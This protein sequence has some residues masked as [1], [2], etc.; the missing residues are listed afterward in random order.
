MKAVSKCMLFIAVL[1]AA[2]SK[3]PV[4][5]DVND[6]EQ[7]V[8][9]PIGTSKFYSHVEQSSYP[10]VELA[11]NE[12]EAK[13]TFLQGKNGS[14]QYHLQQNTRADADIPGSKDDIPNYSVELVTGLTIAP[15]SANLAHVIIDDADMR[16]TFNNETSKTK[17]T[18]RQGVVLEAMDPYGQF[19]IGAIDQGHI[20]RMAMLLPN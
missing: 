1:L 14:Y 13:W 17:N 9:P 3:T 7:L 4:P 8:A 20:I 5:D 2:C 16:V 6:T 18:T 10:R 11:A 19:S 15:E 12:V